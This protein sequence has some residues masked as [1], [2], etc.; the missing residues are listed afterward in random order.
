MYIVDMN[1]VELAAIVNEE[2]KQATGVE[3]GELQRVTMAGLAHR[4]I[5]VLV[6]VR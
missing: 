4:K 2:E 1:E 6:G 3:V 5:V